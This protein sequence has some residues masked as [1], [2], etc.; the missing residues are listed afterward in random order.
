MNAVTAKVAAAFGAAAGTYEEAAGVQREVA[1]ALA[2]R[3]K[4][5]ALPPKPEILEI[6]C[7]TGFLTRALAAL[8]GD[9]VA[10]D[11]SEAM[12]RRC[13]ACLRVVMD[14]QAPCV[15]G[16]FD[17]ICSSLA[18]QWLDDLPQALETYA[19][20]LNPGG[21][22]AFATLGEGTFAE[23]DAAL[24]TTRRQ[25]PSREALQRMLPHGRVEE[26]QI[27]RR[28]SNGREFLARLRSIGA[29]RAN[30]TT[31]P[32]GAGALRRALRRFDDG[33]VVTYDVLYGTYRKP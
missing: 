11:I 16:T 31:R 2:V 28:Y 30:P 15:A 4:T 20:M 3:I 19:A 33:I 12:V 17:L 5:L 13:Q 9:I 25:Y 32:I 10:T 26:H 8:G 22:L 24:N 27:R 14:G 18:F 1:E 6:G 21:V 23:W 7:G 29:H